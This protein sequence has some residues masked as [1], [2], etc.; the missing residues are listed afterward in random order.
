VDK[1]AL[2]QKYIEERLT[3]KL[4]RAMKQYTVVA[5]QSFLLETGAVAEIKDAI[6]L[7][8]IIEQERIIPLS[9]Q[10]ARKLFDIPHEIPDPDWVEPSPSR[11]DD[12]DET[13]DQ[14]SD[15]EGQ[16]PLDHHSKSSKERSVER[17][18][19]ATT[20]DH[21]ETE[22]SAE[23]HTKEH[24]TMTGKSEIVRERPMIPIHLPEG[25]YGA[26]IKHTSE[27]NIFYSF[28]FLFTF[29]R[30]HREHFIVLTET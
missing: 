21:I 28:N 4:V 9:E 10:G 3:I 2:P 15:I 13:C 5:V 6:Q 17:Q 19:G 14:V 27:A 22:S 20:G 30:R 7:D 11:D 12:P 1:N 25:T 16:E 8:F 24:E 29:Y 18:I 23:E 26:R